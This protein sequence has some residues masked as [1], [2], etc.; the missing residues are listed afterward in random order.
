MKKLLVLLGALGAL[1]VIAWFVVTSSGFLKA[2]VLPRVGSALNARVEAQSIALSPF[3]SLELRQFNLVPN[4]ADPLAS[5]ELV[6]VRYRLWDILGGR[7]AVDEILVRRPTLSL[8]QKAD[9][10]SNLDPILRKLAEGAAPAAPAPAEPAKPPQV[11]IASIQ[12]EEGTLT[13][14]SGAADGSEMSASVSGLGVTARNLANGK[15]GRLEVAA[16]LQFQQRPGASGAAGATAATVSS[17]QGRLTGGFDLGLS[18][19]LIPSSMSGKADVELAQATGAF[20]EFSG[21]TGVLQADLTPTELKRLAL[22]FARRGTALGAIRASGPLDLVKREGTVQVEIEAIDRNVLN[23]AGAA[24]GMD[25]TTTRFDST[26]RVELAAGGQRIAIVGAVSG[27]KVSVKKGDLVMPA[28]DLQKGYDMVADLAAQTLSLRSFALRGVQGGREIL[29]GKLS[30]P[31]QVSWGTAQSTLPDA[32]VDLAVQDLRLADWSVLVGTPLQGSVGAQ[33]SLGVQRGGKDLS[34][35]G[36]ATL[37]GLSGTFGSNQVKNLRLSGVVKA[38]VAGFATPAERRLTATAAVRDLGG[39]AAGL[40]F[41]QYTMTAQANLGLPENAVVIDTLDVALRQADREGGT[42]GLRGRWDLQRGAG[43]LNLSA[44]GLNEAGVGPFLQVALGDK[45]LRSLKMEASLAARVDPAAESSISGSAQVQDLVVRDPAGTV[46]ESP[47]AAGIVLDAGGSRDQLSVRQAQLKLTPTARAKNEVN[48]TGDLD[49]SRTNALKGGFKLVSESLDVTPY[50]DLFAG[51]P[52]PETPAPA[53]QPAPK[54]AGPATEPEAVS[55]PV[56]TLTFD[57]AI[58]KFFL[59]EVA[60]E[61]VAATVRIQGSRIDVDPVQLS[62]NG[63]PVKASAKFNLGVPGYEY[64][65]KLSADQVPV[66]P[67]ADS[68]VPMLKNRVE[69]AANAGLDLRGAGITGVNLQKSLAGS[70][71]FV[72]T[73]ANLK[74]NDPSRQKGILSMLTG[75]LATALNIREL[76]DQPIMDIVARATMGDARIELTEAQARSASLTLGT[77]GAIPIAADLMQSPL[78]FPV[79]VSLSRDLAQKA[80]LTSSDTPTNAAY[81]PIPQIAALKGTLGAPA[82]EV[83]KVQAG[84]LAARGVAGLVGG[85]TGNAVT[86]VADAITGLKRGDTN[87]VGNLLKGIGGLFG[88]GTPGATNAGATTNTGSPST[89]AGAPAGGATATTNA[90]AKAPANDPIGGLLRGLLERK[91][92]E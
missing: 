19:A 46:P 88:G 49:F 39:E 13:Y 35:D 12:I 76:K 69:G 15:S 14:R 29:T 81:V 87:A 82:P 28:V 90:P 21:F 7:V 59:R 70:A 6:R 44:R 65:L 24:M 34:L 30:Q 77:Q 63:A 83:D 38:V 58:G 50:F 55:L 80:R 66:K 4:G 47:L 9:G 37:T 51:A 56:D 16:G 25:F 71:S 57:A 18:E 61:N 62:L 31:M 60:A 72:V 27:S 52:K 3:S 85:Q 48:L 41:T 79:A 67:F 23:L 74:I 22:E 53:P 68:F 36:S 1:L 40:S 86:G 73:N 54:P 45:Q 32:T 91:K 17:V 78:N 75:L 2:V 10:T 84:V 89:P 26:N 42:V 33:A 92:S 43:E 64:D 20:Q 5:A 8:V 11:E